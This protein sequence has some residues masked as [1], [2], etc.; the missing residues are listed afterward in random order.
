MSRLWKK[1]HVRGFTLIELLVVI[2]IIAI[3]AGLLLPAIANARERANRIQC[4]N[5]LK[6]FGTALHLYEDPAGGGNWP[7][8][9]RDLQEFANQP[10]LFVCKSDRGR[11]P[12]NT[13]SNIVEANCS[14]N[15]LAPYGP[16]DNGGYIMAF[17]KNG[18]KSAN[19]V[20]FSDG[21]TFDFGTPAPAT[22]DAWGGNH[23]GEGGNAVFIDG[24]SEWIAGGD[25]NLTNLLNEST[26]PENEP[27]GSILTNNTC[28]TVYVGP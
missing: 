13:V 11:T 27:S 1:I 21:T 23:N 19:D 18:A 22:A 25:R 24:H 10:K 16:S 26:F 15:Y 28:E 8:D 5:N 3:L 20:A 7:G 17:D 2:A 6:Q 9:L 14:Y 4:L 12:A